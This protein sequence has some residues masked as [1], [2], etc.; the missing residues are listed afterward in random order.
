M[1]NTQAHRHW[2]L[3]MLTPGARPRRATFG[4]VMA[5]SLFVLA[6]TSPLVAQDAAPVSGAGAAI[7]SLRTGTSELTP[8]ALD[9]AD[10]VSVGLPL[11]ALDE[12]A[13][14]ELR[15]WVNDGGVVFLHTDAAQ[16]FGYR[17]VP[18]RPGTSRVAGQLFGRARA[19]LPSGAH[20]LLWGSTSPEGVRDSAPAVA[21]GGVGPN[22]R[23]VFY[24]MRPGD[25][26]V[27][28]HP[29]GVPLLRVTD[30]AAPD[31]AE[32]FAAAIAPYGRGW[33]VFTPDFIDPNRADGAAFARNLSAFVAPLPASPAQG[34]DAGGAS[35]GRYVALPASTIES[36]SGAQGAAAGPGSAALVQELSQSLN[37][38][39]RPDAGPEPETDAEAP[40]GDGTAP[41]MLPRT[42][43]SSL[44]RALASPAQAPARRQALVQTLR[45]RLE[46]QRD[47]LDE[48]QSWIAAAR[49]AVPGAAEVAVWSGVVSSA[50]AEDLSLSS[51]VRAREWNDAALA[52]GESLRLTP[53]LGAA[54]AA[55][56]TQAAGPASIGGVARALVAAWAA[57]A[58]QAA[59]LSAVEPP[60]VTRLGQGAGAVWLRHYPDDPTLR[61]ALPFGAWLSQSAR[62]I[63]WRAGDEEILVFPSPALFQAYRQASGM[64][65]APFSGPLARYGDVHG[66]R[67]ALVARNTV[68]APVPTG[69]NGQVRFVNL[70]ASTAPIL[71]RLHAQVLVNALAQD[72]EQFP[73]WM[74]LGLA[75]L[76]SR[77]VAG[78]PILS[79]AA[80]GVAVNLNQ[81]AAAGVLLAPRQFDALPVEG[82]GTSVAEAQASALVGVLLSRF[83]AGALAETLQRIGAGE[84]VDEAM[85]ATTGLTE[86]QFFQNWRSYLVTG[87]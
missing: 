11:E 64:A 69:P 63:G 43:A 65:R 87:Q 37:P 56:A 12:E 4:T 16:L 84:S 27:T 60:L 7:L 29:R 83:G 6:A 86:A 18:A 51:R 49:E 31:D 20:P 59:R 35:V 2:I 36:A 17:T 3:P 71:A 67:I 22:V 38:A 48:A 42:E 81:L 26:L 77:D 15:G 41:L 72:S 82:E 75:G 23:V 25:H 28:Q 39:A 73:T 14:A 80:N 30:F 52:W 70:G 44:L 68:T 46:L 61:Y 85:E 8:E 50:R 78:N 34:A 66:S 74:S 9:R 45:A 54:S 13:R 47:R 57:S 10:A 5:A 1:E 21:A 53:I 19:A 62:L 33:A 76:L 24:Q 40:A 32:L 58:A 79:V 55:G